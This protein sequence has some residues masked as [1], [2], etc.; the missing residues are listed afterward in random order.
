MLLKMWKEFWH[1]LG[2]TGQ[3]KIYDHQRI[4]LFSASHTLKMLRR[5]MNLESGS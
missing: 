2:E 3:G 5:C 1:L 4:E